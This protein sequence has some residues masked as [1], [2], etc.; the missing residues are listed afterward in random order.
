MRKIYLFAVIFA[1]LAGIATYFFVNSLQHNSAVTGVKEADVLI[2]LQDIEKDTIVTPEMFEVIKLPVSSITYGTLVSAQDVN[3]FMATETIRKG[4]QVLASKLTDLREDDTGIESNGEYR[5]SYHL[6]EGK[7]AYTITVDSPGTYAVGWFLRAGDYINIY[8]LMADQA[9]NPI[10]KNIPV[11]EVGTYSDL[12]TGIETTTYTVLTL[13]VTEEQIETLIEIGENMRIALVPYAEGAALT[14][15]VTEPA[16]DADGNIIKGIQEP[17]TN[18]GMG[19]LTTEPPT[20][21]AAS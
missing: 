3:G 2:A 5:L 8:D 19:E 16:T 14:T 12:Q 11:L 6:G 21:A 4:E 15:V 9:K 7:Y 1:L 17:E 18:V 13:S 10:L 20:T